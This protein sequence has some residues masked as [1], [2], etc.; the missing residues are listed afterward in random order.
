MTTIAPMNPIKFSKIPGLL[1]FC[2]QALLTLVGTTAITAGIPS[3]DPLSRLVIGK[4]EIIYTDAQMPYTMDGS[5]AS[6][7][8]DNGQMVF[9]E[10]AMAKKPYYFRHTGTPDDPLK[11]E[12]TP[13]VWDYNG[14]NQ[15]WPSGA[16]IQNIY[17]E[18]DGTLV[19]LVHREDLFP[20]NHRKDKGNSFFI[21]L[22]RSTDGG[23][24]WKYL[25]DVIATRANGSTDAGSVNIG[26]VPY[27]IVDGYLYL[28]FNEHIGPKATDSRYLAVARTSLDDLRKAV[29]RGEVPVFKKYTHGIW[30]EDGMTGQGSEIIPSSRCRNQ[31][32]HVVYDF[33]SDA[34]Y[35]KPLGR[36]LITVQT[37]GANTLL[38]YSS[39]NGVDWR[40]AA[41]LDHAPHCMLPYSSFVSFNPDDAPDG[42]EIG[43]DF[44]IY[45]PRKILKDYNKDTLCRIG[46]SVKP[47]G[48]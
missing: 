20:G 38:L 19:G 8:A 26:G 3:T 1:R 11:K 2:F 34:T 48:N 9:F 39:T 29:A 41:T 16:W 42:H 5:W 22:A 40:L 35:C 30:S 44:F 32:D 21:G 47:P 15:S 33:H 10:T 37:H 25:G 6:L 27:L 24:H 46:F 18:P 45:Y 43:S 36:Y 13:F 7:R 12:L 31:G 23:L 17:K 28:Y 14:Y 4:P